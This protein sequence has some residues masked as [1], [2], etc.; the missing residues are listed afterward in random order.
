M[1][2][3]AAVVAACALLVP[4]LAAAQDSTRNAPKP[5][6]SPELITLQ[7]IDAAG[8]DLRTAFELVERL[9]PM[10]MRQTR[11]AQSIT[12]GTPPVMVY[13]NDVR[14]GTVVALNEIPRAAVKEIRHLRPTDA[15]QRFGT[16]HG[17]GAILLYLK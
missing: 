8:E 12:Q 7:E 9:R 16:D 6:R 5:R 15:T 14:R 10:W 4:S 2:R 13:V 17:S 11:G 3:L 1:S